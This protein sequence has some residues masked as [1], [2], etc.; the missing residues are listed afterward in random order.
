MRLSQDVK[1]ELIIIKMVVATLLI[2]TVSKST[3]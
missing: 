1:L 3:P 2:Q